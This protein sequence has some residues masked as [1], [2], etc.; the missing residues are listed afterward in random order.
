MKNLSDF[1]KRLA[2]GQKIETVHEKYGS[3]GVRT[4]SKIQ[5]NSFALLTKNYGSDGK[6]IDDGPKDSWCSFP[7][8]KDF[9][10][11]DQDTVA[12]YWGEGNMREKIL[13]YKF[14]D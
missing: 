10:I 8:S 14:L 13:T 4:V 6:P 7:K 12:I 11:I 2:I 5:S 3:F 1:K 9:E